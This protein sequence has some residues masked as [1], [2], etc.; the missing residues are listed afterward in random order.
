[1]ALNFQQSSSGNGRRVILIVCIAV[2]IA[3]VVIYANESDDGAL[4]DAQGTTSELFSPLTFVGS[5]IGSGL[6]DAANAIADLTA[7][8]DS[9]TALQEANAELVDLLAQ[10]DEYRQEAERLQALLDLRDAYDIE[11]VAAN[12]IGRSTTA[13]DQTITIDKGSDDGIDTGLTVMGSSGVV[14]MVV[15]VTE[16]TATVRLIT[17]PQ[18]GAAAM[19]QSSRAEGIVTGSL[20]GLLYLED[21]DADADVE[22]GDI[23]VTS[24]LGGSYVSGLVIGTVVKVESQAGDTSIRAVVSPN[25]DASTLEEVLVVFNVGS[26]TDDDDDSDDDSDSDADA[27]GSDESESDELTTDESEM[28][29]TSDASEES[30]EA[31]S[32]D[33]E[34]S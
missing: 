9:I 24:G 3:L 1:M 32:E 21:L 27:D 25:E 29:E 30:E 4:H 31:T 13:W 28:A 33:G 16:S 26:S 10:A 5:G 6:T 23:V 2:A 22:V 19:V 20:E 12:V 15:D 7:D 11:G 8:E 18:S 34:V 14:G 17:D